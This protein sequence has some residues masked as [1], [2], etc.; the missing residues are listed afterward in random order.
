MSP[1]KIRVSP[2]VGAL[3]LTREFTMSNVIPVVVRYC[4]LLGHQDC[5]SRL[6]FGYLT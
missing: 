3:T 4:L 2:T 6:E 1:P 5:D